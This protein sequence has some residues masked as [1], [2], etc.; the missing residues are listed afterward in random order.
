MTKFIPKIVTYEDVAQ[1]VEQPLLGGTLPTGKPVKLRMEAIAFL[2]WMALGRSVPAGVRK[3]RA[4]DEPL[5][6]EEEQANLAYAAKVVANAARFISAAQQDENGGWEEIW[7]PVQLM[8]PG[9]KPDP[10]RPDATQKPI[11]AIDRGWNIFNCFNALAS[12]ANAGGPM[13]HTGATEFRPG[14]P[15]DDGVAGGGDKQGTA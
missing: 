3:D 10:R 8:A 9:D 2:D 1:W 5:S 6:G 7:L 15:G 4:P 12:D 11:A 14:R 13:A